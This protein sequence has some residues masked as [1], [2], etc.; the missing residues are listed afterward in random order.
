MEARSRL[1]LGNDSRAQSSFF[2]LF[3]LLCTQLTRRVVEE[4]DGYAPHILE[5]VVGEVRDP[6]IYVDLSRWS[7]VSSLEVVDPFALFV[8]EDRVSEIVYVEERIW[9][10]GKILKNFAVIGRH[11]SLLLLESTRPF[12]GARHGPSDALSLRRASFGCH[13]LA[14][15][16]APDHC[17]GSETAFLGS[18][19]L[20][21]PF[22]CHERFPG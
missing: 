22:I 1:D 10:R 5:L 7:A 12:A 3:N 15:G 13:E 20:A 18:R 19:I 4:A 11:G 8:R 21:G 16:S 14:A 6:I 17:G 9:I 2:G